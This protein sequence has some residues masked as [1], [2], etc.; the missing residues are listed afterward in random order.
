VAFQT[1]QGSIPFV[2]LFR[3]TLAN[4]LPSDVGAGGNASAP[5]NRNI[6]RR[7]DDE[8]GCTVSEPRAAGA[9]RHQHDCTSTP[10]PRPAAAAAAPA[11]GRLHPAQRRGLLPEQPRHLQPHRRPAVLPIRRQPV[12]LPRRCGSANEACAQHPLSLAGG[13]VPLQRTAQHSR[14]R[15]SSGCTPPPPAGFH[16][17]YT[18]VGHA[19]EYCLHTFQAADAPG[20]YFNCLTAGAWVQHAINLAT[21]SVSTSLA[22]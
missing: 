9:S 4:S 20:E 11:G 14:W 15:S 2:Q 10:R 1:I 13:V 8:G 18:I 16:L 6:T 22:H 17:Y 12:H 5:A 7:L 19:A 21:S 3:Q